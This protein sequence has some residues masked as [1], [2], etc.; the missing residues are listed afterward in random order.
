[1]DQV[2][3]QNNQSTSQTFVHFEW[4]YLPTNPFFPQVRLTGLFGPEPPPAPFWLLW[5]VCLS[6]P[7]PT[8]NL[9]WGEGLFFYPIILLAFHLLSVK[10]SQCCHLGWWVHSVLTDCFMVTVGLPTQ[11]QNQKN[12]M[13]QNYLDFQSPNSQI[14]TTQSALPQPLLELECDSSLV[15]SSKPS[16]LKYSGQRL[17]RAQLQSCVA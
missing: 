9:V 5:N 4:V 15:S 6:S 10:T 2:L 12:R 7:G 16:T 1:M 17:R 8:P 14:R 3:S 11:L 13:D